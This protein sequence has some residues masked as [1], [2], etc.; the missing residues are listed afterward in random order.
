M[1]NAKEKNLSRIKSDYI[2]ILLNLKMNK[3]FFVIV[4]FITCI[5]LSFWEG[6]KIFLSLQETSRRKT[7]R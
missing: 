5:H 3:A 4:N 2:Y 1:N 6:G 7:K